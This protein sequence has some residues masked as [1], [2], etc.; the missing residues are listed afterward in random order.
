M[1]KPKRKASRI[2]TLRDS[3]E[4]AEKEKGPTS[5]VPFRSKDIV[6]R[7]ITVPI[8]FPLY[9]IQSGRTHRAQA[10]YLDKHPGLPNNFFNDPEDPRVQRAQHKILLTMITEKDLDTDLR[11][12]GQRFALVL[13]K[14]GYVV[15]GNRRL[16]ALRNKKVDYVNAVVLPADA[17]SNE[18]YETEIELQMQ[19]ETKAPYNWIDQGLH[20]EYG[21]W[22]LGEKTEQ[23]AQRMRMKKEDILLSLEKLQ[24][25]KQYLSW[26]GEDEKY[27]KVPNP[28]GGTMEQ[29]F[30]EIAQRF[31]RPAF[32]RKSAKERRLVRDACFSAIRM[33][34][35]Y[36]QIRTLITQFSKNLP[37]ISSR[38]EDRLPSDK[39]RKPRRKSRS[40]QVGSSDDPLRTLAGTTGSSSSPAVEELLDAVNDP[41]TAAATLEIAEEVEAEEKES[42]RQKQPLQQLQRALAQLKQVEIDETTPDLG[43][44]ARTLS[45]L[46]DAAERLSKKVDKARSRQQTKR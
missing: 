28:R 21:I 13:T 20:I 19:R 22:E 31:Q 26:L 1:Q 10:E 4:V 44:I 8:D 5:K 16:A 29:S 39:R 14:D 6:L 38:L 2:A 7:E 15:D 9:R 33:E 46:I 11:Q 32:K 40:K 18:I 24:F 41:D 25:V 35:G 42:K 36:Q 12:K 34:G 37:K 30:V 23:V 45:Q 27:H 17:K 43:V 3:M